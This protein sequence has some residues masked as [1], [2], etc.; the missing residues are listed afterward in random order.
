[1]ISLATLHGHL[2]MTVAH[3][4]MPQAAE[5]AC[6]ERA[7]STAVYSW[8]TVAGLGCIILHRVLTIH[9]HEEPKLLIHM[10]R[11]HEAA[12]LHEVPHGG[13]G[14]E[15]YPGACITILGSSTIDAGMF[16]LDCFL[17]GLL[18]R[19]THCVDT[20]EGFW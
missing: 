9:L 19:K 13:T 2:S 1:M 5:Q 14:T 10:R 6:T 7:Q 4:T 8:V 12:F 17:S 3:R 16:V 15:P 11:L 18:Q 20:S